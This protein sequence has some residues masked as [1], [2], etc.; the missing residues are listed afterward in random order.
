MPELQKILRRT[1]VEA[2]LGLGR[3]AVY[4]LMDEGYLP[5]PIRLSKRRVGWL[6]SEIIAVQQRRIAERNRRLAEPR[7]PRRRGKAKS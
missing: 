6:E 3:S 5:K 2:L 1:D 7:K 4:A